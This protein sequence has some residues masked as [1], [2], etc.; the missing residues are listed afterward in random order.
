MDNKGVL[1]IGEAFEFHGMFNTIEMP[2]MEM[3]IYGS[4]NGKSKQKQTYVIPTMDGLVIMVGNDYGSHNSG[5]IKVASSEGSNY[6]VDKSNYYEVYF[7]NGSVNFK[8]GGKKEPKKLKSRKSEIEEFYMRNKD[9]LQYYKQHPEIEDSY[10]YDAINK[11][12]K[13]YLD[14]LK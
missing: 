6:F 2:L 4:K 14:N 10:V 1:I 8:Y 7:N 11:T 3:N 13:E 12:E 9:I 5:R